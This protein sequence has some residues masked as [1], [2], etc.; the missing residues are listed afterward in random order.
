MT[1]LVDGTFIGCSI[2]HIVVDGTTFWHFFNTWSG[3]SR[4]GFGSG[5]IS[6]Q[7]LP[8]LGRHESLDA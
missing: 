4:I 5:K 6:Q 3:I 1:E 7:P 2:N 8:F